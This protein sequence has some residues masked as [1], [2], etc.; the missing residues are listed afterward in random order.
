MTAS[1]RQIE[2]ETCHAQIHETWLAGLLL[3]FWLTVLYLEGTSCC[4]RYTVANLAGAQ[5]LRGS[6]RCMCMCA[7][8]LSH[9]TN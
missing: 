1:V 6:L 5:L 4:R 3:L 7:P 8:G 2:A 9:S